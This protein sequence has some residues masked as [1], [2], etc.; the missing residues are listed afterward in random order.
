[1]T[2]YVCITI[3]LFILLFLSLKPAFQYS[4]IYSIDQPEYKKARIYRI[5]ILVLGFASFVFLWYL[6][7]YRSAAIGNDTK[8]YLYYF[9]HFAIGGRDHSSRIEIGYQYLNYF[10]GFFTR[11][12]H[13]FLI[14]MAT[15]MYGG[16]ALYIFMYSKNPVVSLCLFFGLFFSSFTSVLRQG[17]AMVIVLYGY[18]LLKNEK[19][20]PAAILFLLATSIH[21]TAVI[22][23]FLFFHV[24]LLQKPWIVFAVTILCVIASLTGVMK[25]VIDLVLPRYTRY[26]YGKYASTGWMAITYYLLSYA[27][28]YYLVIRSVDPDSRSDRIVAANFAFLMIITAF[29]YAMNLFERASEYFL[30]IGVVEL[31]NML[32]RNKLKHARLWLFAI[33]AVTL[34]MFIL[35]LVYRP[36][37]NHLYPYEFWH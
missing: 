26:F 18:Q 5:V 25:A 6:T 29:G 33:T 21:T 8:N 4:D 2:L 12:R 32:C 23:F 10:I 37:W 1:M 28:Y 13:I 17:V 27:L 34:I 14:I 16:T 30:L 36:G 15:L 3:W 24:K 20:I 7:G 9:T 22:S 31:P 11:N 19:R 35:I